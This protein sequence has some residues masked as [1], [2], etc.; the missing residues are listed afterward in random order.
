M[1]LHTDISNK[2]YSLV[3]GSHGAWRFNTDPSY[4]KREMSRGLREVSSKASPHLTLC[5][6]LVSYQDSSQQPSVGFHSPPYE[7]LFNLIYKI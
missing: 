7:R 2:H 3:A 4:Y 6:S 5:G 1:Q